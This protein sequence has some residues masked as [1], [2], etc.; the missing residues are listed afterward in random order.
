MCIRDSSNAEY[1]AGNLR[2]WPS[3]S[4]RRG[5]LR[6]MSTSD[7]PL[8]PS[9]PLYEAEDPSLKF[10]GQMNAFDR[11]SFLPTIGILILMT[12][13]IGERGQF[14]PEIVALEELIGT[15][16]AWNT[17]LN[18]SEPKYLSGIT[19]LMPLYQWGYAVL[20]NKLC[21][22]T[23][24]GTATEALS[25][26]T[27]SAKAI[28]AKG[29][30]VRLAD[31]G[32]VRVGPI[33]AHQL[34]RVSPNSNS[35]STDDFDYNTGSQY[36]WYQNGSESFL[37]SSPV[38]LSNQTMVAHLSKW[39]N[40]VD[41][42][43]AVGFFDSYPSS[44]FYALA[45]DAG[46]AAGYPYTLQMT[47]LYGA[48]LL[49]IMP[50]CVESTGMDCS[51][52]LNV[53]TTAGVVIDFVIMNPYRSRDQ[54]VTS[55]TV[56]VENAQDALVYVS[57]ECGNTGSVPM[58]YDVILMVILVFYFLVEVFSM[59]QLGWDY[60]RNFWKFLDVAQLLL[61]IVYIVL[62]AGIQLRLNQVL[63]DV[64]SITYETAVKVSAVRRVSNTMTTVFGVASYLNLLKALRYMGFFP[65]LSLP[66]LTVLAAG[67][68]LVSFVALTLIL[69]LA[70][71]AMAFIVM[72][73]YRVEYMDLSRSVLTMIQSC[74]A[75]PD[76]AFFVEGLP[77]AYQW[78]ANLTETFFR[79]FMYFIM[80]PIVVAV[81]AYAYN[82]TKVGFKKV[83]FD[84]ER[85]MALAKTFRSRP[86]CSWLSRQAI[87][88]IRRLDEEYV[89]Q[90]AASLAE[91]KTKTLD[92]CL[93]MLALDLQRLIKQME[94]ASVRFTV[95]NSLDK[96]IDMLDADYKMTKDVVFNCM[97]ETGNHLERLVQERESDAL[98][99]AKH[100]SEATTVQP[101]SRRRGGSVSGSRKGRNLD[102]GDIRI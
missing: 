13:M 67:W 69:I 44:G 48:E 43:S 74:I 54:S 14:M 6:A 29:G 11:L 38:P 83:L 80:L 15:G 25:G 73:P 18:S 87:Y 86:F 79:F 62:R 63:W 7:G 28:F 75:G 23:A 100:D 88:E 91:A 37:R 58:S 46:E 8:D 34:R 50:L 65:L 81:V 45:N 94:H 39:Q 5:A 30:A 32:S 42:V 64:S 96:Q 51:T 98:L 21:S 53:T 89:A 102:L 56:L 78:Y 26:Y 49:R 97:Q 77:Q 72:A 47:P 59:H 71:G 31:P 76:H 16:V 93:H 4:C 17:A 99:N 70:F 9:H 2:H 95:L 24:D 19:T 85:L 41:P 55:C 92:G 57:V 84:T 33:A 3:A 61:L 40:D 101:S 82:S 12:V 1:G 27:D 10:F 90:R 35:M 20:F 66:I 36:L 68:Q 22:Y 60:I 52:W